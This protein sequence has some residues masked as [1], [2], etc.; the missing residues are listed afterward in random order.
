MP[1]GAF[2]TWC[3]AATRTHGQLEDVCC[4]WCTAPEQKHRPWGTQSLWRRWA[5]PD[6]RR[7]SRLV[8]QPL[9]PV[10]S[11]V[12]RHRHEQVLP[13]P[14]TLGG[15]ACPSLQNARHRLAAKATPGQTAHTAKLKLLDPKKSGEEWAIEGRNEGQE[16]DDSWSAQLAKSRRSRFAKTQR[17]ELSMEKNSRNNIVFKGAQRPIL[18]AQRMPGGCKDA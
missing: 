4:R 12:P 7:S 5:L 3:T 10:S 2:H 14:H 16:E 18:I 13:P 6:W 8:M 11:S 17:D 1:S 9:P 15:D